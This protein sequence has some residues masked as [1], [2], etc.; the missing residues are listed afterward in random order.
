MTSPV[1]PAGA[2]TPAGPKTQ[3]RGIRLPQLLL[4]LL[5]VAV[6]A[7]LAVWWQASTTSRTP[8]LALA[9]DV[10]ADVPLSAADL[11]EIYVSSDVP[12]AVVAAEFADAFVGT[13]PVADLSAG[14]FI[15]GEMVQRPAPLLAGQA[16]AGLIIDG[17]RAP[18]RLAT[19]DR[20]QVLL[21]A[22]DGTTEIVSP[23]ARVEFVDVV[24]AELSVQLRLDV[25]SAQR[26]Q[27]NATRVV[28]IEIENEGPAPWEGE[29][30]S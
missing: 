22:P 28:L 19:G 18:T 13:R 27:L 5:V 25:N 7:L 29:D 12:A 8:M 24:G 11:T 6:F 23:D 2:I 16:F 3:Q 30:P 17:N 15:T 26:V 21:S 9:N 10:K 1:L 20:V 4:S 14:T